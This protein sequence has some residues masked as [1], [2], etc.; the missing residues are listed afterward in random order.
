LPA[1]VVGGTGRPLHLFPGQQVC[2]AALMDRR[3]LLLRTRRLMPWL[4]A[5]GA[6]L[7]FSFLQ[8][9]SF[10][11]GYHE[12]DPD[13]YFTLMRRLA[14][15]GP[16]GVVDTDPFIHQ[17]HVWVE[18]QHGEVLP[19]YPPGWPTLLAIGYVLGGDHGAFVVNPLLGALGLLGMFL[20]FRQWT[21]PLA[22]AFAVAAMA[23]M[24]SFIYYTGYAL[25]HVSNVAFVT[26]GMYFLWRFSRNPTV[27][28]A[29]GAGLLLGYT[30]AIRYTSAMLVVVAAVALA[31]VWW[32]SI[33]AG[34]RPWW[35]T[36]ALLLA[37]SVFPALLA[38]YHWRYFGSPWTTGYYLS[39]E[40]TAFEWAQLSRN[41]RLLNRGLSDE[42][43]F[44][45]TP[46]A[47]VGILAI[48][49]PAD[50]LMR[51][52]WFFVI[53]VV[54][55]FYYWAGP[56]NWYYRF[57]IVTFPVIAGMAFAVIDR[58]AAR[59]PVTRVLTMA[60]VVA[61]VAI[62]SHP[63]LVYF[64][65]GEGYE[66]NGAPQVARTADQASAHLEP[67]AVIF[68]ERPNQDYVGMR[69]QFLVYDLRAFSD[70]RPRDFREQDRGGR[71]RMQ[72]MRRERFLEFYASHSQNDLTRM[73]RELVDQYLREGRQV[74]FLVP[75]KQSRRWQRWLGRDLTVEPLSEWGPP[76][77]GEDFMRLRQWFRERRPGER[78]TW[79]LYE[80]VPAG[81]PEPS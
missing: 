32:R 36:L 29:I 69:E 80:V 20:L 28:S 22:A 41:I 25:T 37:Y 57:L 13:G 26:W 55:A 17:T 66:E 18:N 54:Y 9:Q 47:I 58:V 49:R 65:R 30:P 16:I 76:E 2:C 24:P 68:A 67:N 46:L 75:Q 56:G 81:Q 71:P 27:G 73:Q 74:V 70:R 4:I 3:L 35:P 5:G 31:A 6:I 64:A 14:S 61:I 53:Y 10:T 77:L 8:Y 79:G 19:K 43:V 59:R 34:R 62:D 12:S 39:N 42:L 52:A 33:R 50:R 23:V 11:P 38:L 21:R 44:M 45:L 78:E 1:R 15:L 40:Q 63:T 7:F 51:A 48:G 60:A 72:P